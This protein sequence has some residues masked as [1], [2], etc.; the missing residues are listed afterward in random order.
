MTDLGIAFKD[1]FGRAPEGCWAAP[2]RVNLIGE[3]TDYNDGHVLPFALP[4]T[5]RAAV[6]RRD[7]G[8]LRVHSADMDGGVVELRVDDLAPG[9]G[10]GWA[11]YPAAVLWTLREAGQ[12]VG[13]AD[14]HYD[15][16]VPVG[17]GLSSSA[18][19]QVVTALAL[20]ELHGVRTGRQELALL[21]QR[22]E[23]VYVGAPVGVMDQTA[24]AC[25]TEG[26]ALHLDVRGLEQ[27]QVPL[28]LA[29][30]GLT[31]LVA[32]TRVKHAH[33]DGAY[34]SL[35]AGC[36]AAASALGLPS[37]RD[38]SHDGLAA[39]L[40]ALPDER[41]R[42]LTRHVVTE[43]RRVEDV[44]ALLDAGRIRDIGPVLTAG[45]LS[46]RDDFQVS[47]PELDLVVDT[48]LDRGALGARM[49]GGG[50]GGSAI[51][52]VPVESVPAVTE[53]VQAA[54]PAARIFAATPSRGA[55]RLP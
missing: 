6:A 52:L 19:L 42:R 16:T 41:L 18:A 20:G 12:P 48:A 49:T 1:V 35:R 55:H 30:N 50:F 23:N 43:N 40:D 21:C 37:L 2:G 28:D 22:S 24:S 10:A 11:T 14:I 7:D 54:L 33:A 45:H 53:A 27:R 51:A 25:C 32:D 47:C 13:G 36:E 15:S 44:I 29:G 4:Q 26:H 5:T 38:V 39:A 46:L 9:T 17:G 31:L 8:L 34:A 3:H